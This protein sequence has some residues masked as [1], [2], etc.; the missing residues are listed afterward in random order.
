MIDVNQV[1]PTISVIPDDL[2]SLLN[3]NEDANQLPDAQLFFTVITD[4]LSKETSERT[5]EEKTNSNL[6]DNIDIDD[7][8]EEQD[9]SQTIEAAPQTIIQIETQDRLPLVE[10]PQFAWFTA[11]SFEPPGEQAGVEESVDL[12]ASVLAKEKPGEDKIVSTMPKN[13]LNEQLQQ[14]DGSLLPEN[15]SNNDSTINY[16]NHETQSVFENTNEVNQSKISELVPSDF[17][18]ENTPFSMPAVIKN[19]VSQTTV[20]QSGIP[21]L[22]LDI[23]VAEPEWSQGFN[24]QIIWLGQQKINS[25]QIKLNPQ[26]F[27]PLEVNI[28]ML[29]DEATLKIT[30]HTLQIR[31][32]VE[33]ALPRLREMMAEQGVNLAQ[34]NI[35]SHEHKEQTPHS[36]VERDDQ[37]AA[38]LI[39]EEVA[40]TLQVRK[41]SGL[42]DYFA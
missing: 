20:S 6:P 25:A 26:E 11:S 31:D 27:G 37:S 8:E 7:V 14:E 13:T 17:K 21:D 36:E 9:E 18:V 35:D 12:P 1:T 15:L 32:L 5:V 29:K 39:T 34:V 19:M 42:V 33:Q 3:S 2:I 28:H 30:T 10:N 4:F 38:Q 40:E 22:S 16:M 24:Q 23:P 41:H